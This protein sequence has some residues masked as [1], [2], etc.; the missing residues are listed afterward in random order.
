M[1]AFMFYADPLSDPLTLTR[2]LLN[3]LTKQFILRT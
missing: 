2:A 1:Y 3:R